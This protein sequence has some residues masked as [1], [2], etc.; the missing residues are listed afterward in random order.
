VSNP[1]RP[2]V[3]RPGWSA[4]CLA[5]VVVT[6]LGCPDGPGPTEAPQASSRKVAIIGWD[7][8]TWRVLDPMLRRGELPNLEALVRRGSRAVLEA[9]PPLL[10][11]VLWTTIATGFPPAEHGITAF[12]LPDP[13]DGRTVLASSFHRRRAPLW[14]IASAEGKSVGFV[15]WWTTW[16]AEPVR[17]WLVSDHLAYNRY[18]DWVALAEGQ[19]FDLTFPPS[20]AQN[21]APVAVQPAQVGLETVTA[22]VPFDAGEQ[23]EMMSATAPVRFHAPSVMRFGYATDASNMAFARRLLETR[24]QPDLFAVVLVLGDIAG[25]SFWHHYEPE[26]YPQVEGLGRLREAIP[27][28]YRQIDRWTGE[29]IERLAPDTTI[30][31][32]SDHGMGAK[33]VL[34]QP[35]VNPAGDHTPDGIL[36]VAGPGIA[37]GADVGTATSVDVVPTVLAL[38]DLPVGQDMPGRVVEGVFAARRERRFVPSHGPGVTVLHEGERPPT[39]EQYLER[40]RSLGYVK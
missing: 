8:A 11:P 39:D 30:V 29:I 17:G 34:P 40:L 13:R 10:S 38:L 21:L 28:V 7:A 2:A 24:G 31:V 6:T 23:R 37:V 35:G 9:R 4:A 16:P 19:E 18:D 12:E 26:L 1:I 5:I 22:L 33:R 20:L 36:V 3:K 15:G 32:L 14:Q 27:N 25:H